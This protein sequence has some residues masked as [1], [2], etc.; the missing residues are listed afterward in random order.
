MNDD[1]YKFHVPNFRI[2]NLSNSFFGQLARC[3]G[4]FGVYSSIGD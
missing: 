2:M 4:V 3:F 1:V